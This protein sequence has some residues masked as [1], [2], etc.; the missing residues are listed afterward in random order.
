MSYSQVKTPRFYVDYV[1]YLN[2]M[3]VYVDPDIAEDDGYWNIESQSGDFIHSKIWGLSNYKPYVFGAGNDNT[4][5]SAIISRHFSTWDSTNRMSGIMLFLEQCNYFAIFG[6]NLDKLD[7]T[8]GLRLTTFDPETSVTHNIHNKSL[9]ALYNISPSE[10]HYVSSKNSGVSICS[11]GGFGLSSDYHSH[12]LISI[13]LL[14]KPNTTWDDIPNLVNISSISVGR[15]FDMPMSPDLELSQ[16]TLYETKRHTTKGGKVLSKPVN[17]RRPNFGATSQFDSSISN[18]ARTGRKSWE[19]KYS[20]LKDTDIMGYNENSSML[21]PESRGDYDTTQ[22]NANQDKFNYAL[23]GETNNTDFFSNVLHL[24]Q[25]RL[26]F[27]FQPDNTSFGTSDF[28][29][30]SFDQNSFE[31]RQV[32]FK[33]Y[34]TSLSIT[35]SW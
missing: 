15:Y 20:L 22:L 3:G 5:N 34:E 16:T 33:T 13:E 12:I 6:H 2:S 26:P 29:I 4:F 21:F 23:N 17:M 1:Q 9:S 27:I 24:T 8:F 11:F 25:G 31:H 32:G 28:N 30:C 19:L 18:L 7:V 35:E 14:I 10:S